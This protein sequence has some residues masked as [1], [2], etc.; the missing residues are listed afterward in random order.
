MKKIVLLLMFST[1]IFSCKNS[2]EKNTENE[3]TA[4]EMPENA[5]TYQ[6]DFINSDG[7]MVLMGPNFIYGV[8]RNQISEELSNQVE[9]IKENDYDM[10]GVVVRGVVSQNSNSGSE[11]EEEITINQIVRVNDTPS[12]VDIKLNESTKNN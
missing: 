8:N 11:W 4:I 1:L 10:V 6:G 9:A 7:A 5:K 12:E 2:Q 3:E